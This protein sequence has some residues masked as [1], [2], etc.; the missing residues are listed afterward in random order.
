M[1][2]N[3]LCVCRITW[4]KYK[5]ITQVFKCETFMFVTKEPNFCKIGVQTGKPAFNNLTFS[6]VVIIT[7]PKN[8]L[9]KS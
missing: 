7:H 2:A 4:K 6:S 8:G 5:I 9:I 1:L 3:H